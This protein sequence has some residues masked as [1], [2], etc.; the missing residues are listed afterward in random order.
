MMDHKISSDGEMWLIIPKL[1]LLP[2]LIWTTAILSLFTFSLEHKT[3]C[4]FCS[5]CMW[6][7]KTKKNND[8]DLL[9]PPFLFDIG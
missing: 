8:Q 7:K 3:W 1:S 5:C 2:L 9:D 6:Q 4:A